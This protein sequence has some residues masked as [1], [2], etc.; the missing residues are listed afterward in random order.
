MQY[1][2]TDWQLD[3]YWVVV[4]M[5]ELLQIHSWAA[6]VEPPTTYNGLLLRVVAPTALWHL[7]TWCHISIADA[8]CGGPLF[9]AAIDY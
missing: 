2:I 5:L 6:V 9:G 3:K 1:R 8:G 7:T 4:H